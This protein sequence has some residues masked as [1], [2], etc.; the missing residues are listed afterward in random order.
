MR[1]QML[2]AALALT[3]G[4][5]LAQGF[6]ARDGWELFRRLAPAETAKCADRNCTPRDGGMY[7]TATKG[8]F[9]SNTEV[10]GAPHVRL[11][12][13]VVGC[14]ADKRGCKALEMT[15][16][17]NDVFKAP[18]ATLASWNA[19]NP[20]CKAENGRTLFGPSVVVPLTASTKLADIDKARKAVIACEPGFSRALK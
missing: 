1:V 16:N 19:A 11:Y 14:G 20:G 18:P 7:E 17:Y 13:T 12:Y 8:S 2:A 6:D 4:A 5:A 9:S 3:A 10:A 15:V